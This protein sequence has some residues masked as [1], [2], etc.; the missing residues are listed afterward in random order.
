MKYQEKLRNIRRNRDIKR[1]P[2]MGLR[3]E[4][5][6]QET[7]SCLNQGVSHICAHQTFHYFFLASVY[8]D[9]TKLHICLKVI[10]FCVKIETNTN[11]VH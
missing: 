2:P 6:C 4:S 10:D 5:Q 11:I 8:Y 7:R 3:E 9:M 1:N